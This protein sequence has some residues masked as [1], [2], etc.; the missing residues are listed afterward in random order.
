LEH[1]GRAVAGECAAKVKMEGSRFGYGQW[2]QIKNYLDYHGHN[3]TSK[4]IE[5][6]YNRFYMTQDLKP[7]PFAR[8]RH[9]RITS[10]KSTNAIHTPTSPLSSDRQQMR[11]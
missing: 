2:A 1:A 11:K 10:L 6:H 7:V 8:D 3:F 5:E 4:Q 9:S